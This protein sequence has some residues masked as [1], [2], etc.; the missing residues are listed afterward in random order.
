M[1]LPSTQST[2]SVA[3]LD[4]CVPGSH[5]AQLDDPLVLMD[6]TL[7]DSQLVCPVA[8]WYSPAKHALQLVMP[9][10]FAT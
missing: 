2:H 7:H 5:D 8:D 1:Y 4:E 6:P 9:V 3:L 10:S